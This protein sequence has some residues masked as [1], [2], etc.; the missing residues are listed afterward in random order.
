ARDLHQAVHAA[1]GFQTLRHHEDR[2][3]GRLDQGL[4]GDG[5][6]VLRQ[7]R[8]GARVDRTGRLDQRGGAG[9][10]AADE[11]DGGGAAQVEERHAGARPFVGNGVG[12]GGDALFGA[13]GEVPS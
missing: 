2:V 4:A 8:G 11:V 10:L 5:G 1:D 3:G 9:A 12:D 7:A 6:E 13:A